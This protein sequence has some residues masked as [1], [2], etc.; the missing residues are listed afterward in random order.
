MM[1][2]E[3]RKPVEAKRSGNTLIA[4]FHRA[5]PPLV[6]RFDLERNHSFTLALQGD[7]GEWELG[8]TSPK[9]DFHPVARFA[10]RDDAE[11]AFIK[12]EKILAQS[13]SWGFGRGNLTTTGATSGASVFQIIGRIFLVL[14]ILT[15]IAI[16]G[17]G[18]VLG[19]QFFK[20]ISSHRSGAGLSSLSAYP[21]LTSP[22]RPA[23]TAPIVPQPASPTP[24]PPPAIKPGVPLSADDFLQAPP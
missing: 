11:D 9:G 23:F 10:L 17:C 15:L 4:A 3:S 8:L 5:N 14:L 19:T 6:W 1:T 22:A 20:S 16:I 2:L 13:S 12:V 7:E 18:V 21:P 24:T